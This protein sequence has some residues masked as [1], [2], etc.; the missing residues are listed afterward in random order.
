MKQYEPNLESQ[1]M[2]YYDYWFSVD[3]VEFEGEWQEGQSKIKYEKMIG[4]NDHGRLYMQEWVH[5]DKLNPLDLSIKFF[6]I[7]YDEFVEFLDRAIEQG[8][9]AKEEREDFLEM[10]KAPNEIPWDI[11][12]DRIVYQDDRFLLGQ[13]DGMAFLIA[14]GMR[15]FLTSHPYEPCLYITDDDDSKTI[16]H[17]AFDPFHVLEAFDKGNT[18]TSITGHEYD[19]KSFCEMVAYAAGKGDISIDDAEKVF[20]E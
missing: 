18:V 6:E 13:Q 2:N 8:S 7:T 5:N 9:A 12:E 1:D 10:A 20:K 16:V 3:V 14:D 17:N 19:A 11:S 15:Y 4:Q